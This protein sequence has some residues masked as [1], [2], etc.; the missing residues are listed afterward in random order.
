MTA[1][2]VAVRKTL[3]VKAPIDKAFRV[4]TDGFDSWWPRSHHIGGADLKQAVLEPRTGGRW[5]EIGVDG[6]ECEWGEVLVWEPPQRLVVTWQING[7]WQY[8]PDFRTEVEVRFVA[9][10]PDLTRV[11]FEHRDLERFGVDQ[12]QIVAG[13]NSDGGW[14]GL[15][16]AFAKAAAA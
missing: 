1:T 15:L 2:D 10:A 5:Y 16:E 9:E 13:F 12:E 11:E 4:F 6:S 7:Q 14:T 3:T 8:D